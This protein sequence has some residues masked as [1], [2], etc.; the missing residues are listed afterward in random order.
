MFVLINVGVLGVGVESR[1][2]V[3]WVQSVEVGVG[4]KLLDSD[5]NRD[6][7]TEESDV[8]VLNMLEFD[9]THHHT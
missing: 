7:N 4:K 8:R 9:L 3:P 5:G 1:E 2:L 6:T